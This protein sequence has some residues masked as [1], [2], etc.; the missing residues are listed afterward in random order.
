MLR[1]GDRL[2]L[3]PARGT[4]AGVALTPRARFDGDILRPVAGPQTRLFD[5]AAR[6]RLVGTAFVKDARG[7]RMGQRLFAGVGMGARPGLPGLQGFDRRKTQV[8]HAEARNRV[9]HRLG[10]ARAMAG[11]S[12]GRVRH[13]KLHGALASMATEDEGLAR[14]CIAGALAV[15]PD[16]ILMVIAGTAQDRAAQTLGAR[17][18]CEVFADRAHGDTGPLVDRRHPGAVPS[19]SRSVPSSASP[20]PA[21]SAR[22]ADR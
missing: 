8:S 22:R 2:A 15:N 6:R 18:A 17:R 4:G 7:S 21:P 16:L 12:G 20:S 11:A 5:G 1:A 3:G 19:R 13:L 9:V 10:A 14:A